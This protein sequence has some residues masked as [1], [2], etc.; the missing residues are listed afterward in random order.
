MRA[1]VLTTLTGALMM[2]TG[3][4]QAQTTTPAPAA[5]APS[6][7]APTAPSSFTDADL[8]AFARAAIAANK[9][10]QDAAVTPAEKQPKMLAAVQAQGLDPVKFNAIA[11][12]SEA[13]PALA[14]RI[15]DAARADPSLAAPAPAAPAADATPAPT[16][17]P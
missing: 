2:S 9:I 11:K 12:A 3:V 15:Q 5:P 16:T 4:A 6:A 8:K 1:I 10:Q 7:S 17:T 13:D 14:K